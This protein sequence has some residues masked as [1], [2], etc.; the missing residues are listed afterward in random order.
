MY[1]ELNRVDTLTA[2]QSMRRLRDAGLL[3]QK[4]RGSGTYYQPTP[5]LLESNEQGLSGQSDRLSSNL[6][7]L[8]SNPELLSSNLG[9]LSSNPNWQA[10]P[11]ELQ[12][13]VSAL[14]QRTHPDKA[15]E[16]LIRLCKHRAWQASELAGL[17]N[18]NAHYL[19][20]QYL[21]PLVSAGVLAYTI[22]DQ[23]NHPHQA[24]RAVIGAV[25]SE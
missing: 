6:E 13:M 25:V 24:Y 12:E 3:E 11:Q 7:P 5:W 2:S 23:P 21:R 8:S 15:R 9:A 14:G 18:R 4:G 19:G 20:T 22:P 1:R 16:T 17:F 10:L